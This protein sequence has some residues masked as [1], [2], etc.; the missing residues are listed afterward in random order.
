MGQ[1]VLYKAAKLSIEVE[2][3][4]WSL[5]QT[6]FHWTFSLQTHK[7]IYFSSSY[8]FA[9]SQFL[10]HVHFLDLWYYGL[11]YF[12]KKKKCMNDN[13]IIF[14]QILASTCFWLVLIVSL[15]ILTFISRSL[16]VIIDIGYYFWK[17][18]ALLIREQSN[19][20]KWNL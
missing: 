3:V 10:L 13:Y 14:V 6:F 4:P 7:N 5:F 15:I 1:F 12:K 18:I 11:L 2:Q 9:I 16:Y 20:Y 17:T 19:G 8:P